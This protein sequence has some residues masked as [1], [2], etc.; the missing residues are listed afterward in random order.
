V[1]LVKLIEKWRVRARRKFHDA[2]L[3][4][5][6]MGRKLIEHGALCYFNCSEE[7]QTLVDALPS[8]ATPAATKKSRTRQA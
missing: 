4:P 8:S 1:E 2:K 7:L 5:D 6:V 3:E